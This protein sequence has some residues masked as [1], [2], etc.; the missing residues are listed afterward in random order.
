MVDRFT[1]QSV[2]YPADLR[3][4]S[5]S[6]LVANRRQ[7]FLLLRLAALL[8]LFFLEMELVEIALRSHFNASNLL[9]SFWAP[10]L[11]YQRYVFSFAF[12]FLA[13]FLFVCWP[14]LRTYYSQLLQASDKYQWKYYVVLQIGAFSGFACLTYILSMYARNYS[15]WV[16]ATFLGWLVFFILTGILGFLSLAPKKFWTAVAGREK[17]ALSLAGA[18]G[19]TAIGITDLISKSWD[20]LAVPTM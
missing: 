11:G 14:R 18:V 5:N 12:V 16:L 1:H 4:T 10:I 7:L 15:G 17:V 20:S 3:V 6:L 9:D 8:C 13:A 19:F 2:R